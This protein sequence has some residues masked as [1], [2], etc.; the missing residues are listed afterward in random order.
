MDFPAFFYDLFFFVLGAVIGSFL[1]VL[2]HRLPRE[3]SV[4][5]PNSACPSCQ[6]AIK[7]YDNIPIFS[8][9]LL[10]G[11]CRNCSLAISFR[12]PLVELLTALLFVFCFRHA[13]L[14]LVLPL[15][16]LFISAIVALIFIDSEH[17]IL[18]DAIN[19][20]GILVA[21]AARIGLPLA[22]GSAIF[23]D[24]QHAPLSNL[25]IPLPA[26][27]LLGA[28]L[29][30]AAG[31][32]FLWLLGW[33]WKRLRGVEAMGLGDVKMML[34]VGA[35]LGWRLTLLTLFLAA[36][37]GALS[38]ILLIYSRRERDLQT[39]IPFGIFLGI[40]SIIALFFGNFLINW[41]ISNFIP[42]N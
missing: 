10:R 39:H 38:G 8:W 27:S 4:V 20:P 36:L 31:G 29:G 17:M 23:D 28:I 40:G 16:L 15:E 26:A 18:P 42:A 33:I 9:L 1:N 32:G 22:T 3:E 2:I 35:F 25:Q 37:T 11:R 14:N 5:F 7:P 30:A 24:L 13:G 12:Y 19:Y 21:F 34:W 41:Y 6:A